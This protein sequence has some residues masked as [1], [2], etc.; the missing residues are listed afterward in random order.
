MNGVTVGYKCY[1]DVK[2]EKFLSV[3]RFGL[4]RAWSR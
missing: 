1:R 2:E 3:E 4:E